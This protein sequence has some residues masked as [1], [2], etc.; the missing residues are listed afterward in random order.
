MDPLVLRSSPLVPLT[1]VPIMLSAPTQQTTW[2]INATACQ[3]GKVSK[4]SKSLHTFSACS[5]IVKSSVWKPR[6]KC[7][8]T[9]ILEHNLIAHVFCICRS[10]V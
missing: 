4:F 1:P 9:N 2:G 5:S 6:E 10:V 3:D 8:S 7:A